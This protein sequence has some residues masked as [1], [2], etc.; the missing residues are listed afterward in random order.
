[1]FFL[2]L[3]KELTNTPVLSYDPLPPLDAIVSYTRP[4]RSVPPCLLVC[5]CVC[6]WMCVCM[7]A[8]VR[9]H[10]CVHIH[11]CL[12]VCVS[13]VFLF[14][15]MIVSCEQ[16]VCVCVL[17]NAFNIAS[18]CH[19]VLH[20]TLPIFHEMTGRQNRS[21]MLRYCLISFIPP[22]E[23][24]FFNGTDQVSERRW[25]MSPTNDKQINLLCLNL[26]LGKCF[27]LFCCRPRPADRGE[28]ALSLFVRSLLPNFN[29][30]VNNAESVLLAPLSNT[31]L[32]P[33]RITLR[34]TWGWMLE[35]H[36]DNMR[37]N[38]RLTWGWM[39]ECH[40]AEC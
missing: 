16:I 38:V 39:L 5:V 31:T 8:C 12:H 40:E 18:W 20:P 14:V 9:M 23:Y 15:F 11:V 33:P 24:I 13:C 6:A 7:H 19:G 2:C 35:C 26:N 1:M 28:N 17:M 32:W 25:S 21:S 3:W 36:E 22:Q 4:Q 29:A 27:L 10:V 30:Q 37:L 34:M